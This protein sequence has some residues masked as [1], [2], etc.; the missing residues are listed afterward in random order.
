MITKTKIMM[1]IILARTIIILIIMTT[2][3][4]SNS[5]IMIKSNDTHY[6]DKSNIC[7]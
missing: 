5:Y 7:N 6:G 1:M 4:I 3:I 2:T